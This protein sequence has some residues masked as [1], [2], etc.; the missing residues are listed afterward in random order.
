MRIFF[1]FFAFLIIIALVISGFLGIFP[2]TDQ[3]KDNQGNLLPESIAALETIELGGL[4]QAILIRGKDK[5]NPILLWV[6]GGPGS[7]QMPLAHRLDRELEAEY[8]VVHWDQRGAGK[9]NHGGFREETMTFEQFKEDSVQ[10]VNYLLERFSRDKI[11][12]LG[13]SWGTQLGTEIV[14]DYPDLFYAYIGVSQLV[15][16]REGV[17]IA[18]NWLREQIEGENDQKNLDRLEEIGEP[19]YTH[20]QYRIFAE[21]IS[22]YGGNFDLSMMD[23]A[24]IAIRAPEYNIIDYYRWIQGAN[25][26]GKPL[27]EGEEMTVVNFRETVPELE[28]PV[29]FFAGALDKN[30]PLELIEEYYETLKAP[31]KEII[32][33]E[34]SAHTPFL[35]EPERFN[36]ELIK[37]KEKTG[38]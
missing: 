36:Q 14:R 2:S 17:E 19:P 22:S 25:R 35:G 26:G 16:S 24:L 1:Y 20:P 27:H 34:N 11:F 3:F 7:S 28:V 13:H 5:D 33:F 30:T 9:S 32:V 21:I 31:H 29:F 37:I 8:I 12:L 4:E 23:L 10:L 6:H 38:F 15:D 18:Y